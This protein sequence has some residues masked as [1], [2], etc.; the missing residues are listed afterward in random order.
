MSICHIHCDAITPLTPSTRPQV[1]LADIAEL[2]GTQLPLLKDGICMRCTTTGRGSMMKIPL[3]PDQAKN[4]VQASAPVKE[5]NDD[6][7]YNQ[8]DRPGDQY[9]Q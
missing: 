5:K 2:M 7:D 3:K 4:N 9:R 6:D 1:E 8:D